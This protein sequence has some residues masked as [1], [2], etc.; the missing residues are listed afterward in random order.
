MLLKPFITLCVAICL[1][2]AGETIQGDDSLTQ[3][4]AESRLKQ[5][6]TEIG[7]LKKELERTRTT[8]SD[9]QK[10]LKS[11]DFIIQTNSLELRKLESNRQVHERELARLHTERQSYLRNLDQRR[12]ALAI[13]IMAAYRLSRE[14][15]LKLVLNQDSPA[16]LSRTL[17]YYDYI[18]RSQVS[19]INELRQV[20]QT[21]DKMQEKINM[22]LSVLNEVQKSQQAVLDQM[23]IQR[24]ERRSSLKVYP[25]RLAQMKHD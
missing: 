18:S 3:A 22:E 25:V 15:R 2:L 10:A 16:L 13:Q 14:S 5:L 23:T 21:L 4:Q 6:K 17:A 7:A 1:I 20:L 19:L 11:A 9:E 8:L 24:N 12:E